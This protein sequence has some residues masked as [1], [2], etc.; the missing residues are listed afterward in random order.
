MIVIITKKKKRKNYFNCYREF[1]GEMTMAM[2]K[3]PVT[4]KARKRTTT[5]REVRSKLPR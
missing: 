5:K 4:M 1:H 2:V 3:C